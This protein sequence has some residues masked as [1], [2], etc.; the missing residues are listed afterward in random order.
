MK[1]KAISLW[2]PW[3]SL[4][5]AKAK[6][7]ETRSWATSYRGP[8][9]ICAAKG[10]LCRRDLLD[11]LDDAN[12]QAALL[13]LLPASRERVSVLD[14]LHGRA[15]ALVDLTDCIPTMRLPFENYYKEKDYGN[16]ALGRF[17]WKLENI[18]AINTFPAKGRQGLFDIEVPEE[19]LMAA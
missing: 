6:T 10:G 12:A 13:P 19:I 1:I 8:L 14:L 2:E 3:A 11:F 18:R 15:A 4:I 7:Y 9:L 17:A 5:R 16:Y